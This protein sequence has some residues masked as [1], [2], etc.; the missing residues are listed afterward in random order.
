MQIAG[1]NEL[2]SLKSAC[3]CD[4]LVRARLPCKY[5]QALGTGR[6]QGIEQGSPVGREDTL[7][8]A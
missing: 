6:C 1:A 8:Q 5:A 3:D 2:R 7:L 4:R